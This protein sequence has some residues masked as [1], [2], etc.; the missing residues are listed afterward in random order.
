VPKAVFKLLVFAVESFI[1]IKQL[2]CEVIVWKHLMVTVKE[3]CGIKSTNRMNENM[4][5]RV[6]RLTTVSL[7]V[8]VTP[9]VEKRQLLWT[10]VV[11]EL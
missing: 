6:M 2:N 5:E 8:T 3:L 10:N 7:D 11:Y 9:A 1:K 4:W